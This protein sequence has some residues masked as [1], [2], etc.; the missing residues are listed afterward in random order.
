VRVPSALLRSVALPAVPMVVLC[1][2]LAAC[3]G[4]RS[5]PSR[6]LNDYAAALEAGRYRDAYALLSEDARRDIP[7]AA[8]ERMA[9]ENP[10]EVKEVARSLRRPLAESYVTATVTGADGSKLLLIYEAGA[11]KVDGSAVDL[12]SQASPELAMASF[13]KAFEGKRYDILLRFVPTAKREGLDEKVLRAAWEGEQKQDMTQ[14]VQALKAS[15]P[16]AKVELL[17]DRATVG[18]GPGATIELLREQGVWKIEE[19]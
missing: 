8:F 13:V 1:T 2:T 15:L 5:S 10:E 12:Y 18:Y 14:L 7:Y 9:R 19:L 6:V 3:A 16:T 4:D 11:W 17:G